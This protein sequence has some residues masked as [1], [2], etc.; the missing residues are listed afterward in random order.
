MLNIHKASLFFKSDQ[1]P[2]KTTEKY[3]QGHFLIKSSTYEKYNKTE[4]KRR[5]KIKKLKVGRNCAEL[6][7]IARNCAEYTGLVIVRK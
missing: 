1:R 2:K 5:K 4:I 3:I 6:C 7:G